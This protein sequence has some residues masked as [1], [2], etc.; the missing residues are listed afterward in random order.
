MKSVFS[1][2]TTRLR[3]GVLTA[4]I[5]VVLALPGQT[6]PTHANPYGGY[7]Q[8]APD[9]ADHWYC[10]ANVSY[11]HY[12]FWWAMDHLD[13]ATNI[14]DVY[15]SYCG[16][17][18]DVVFRYGQSPTVPGWLQPFTY[19]FT[20]CATWITYQSKCEQYYV[21]VDDN[22][23]W[24][25][26]GGDV[27]LWDFNMYHVITHEVGHTAGLQHMSGAEVMNA[28][29]FSFINWAYTDYSGHDACH[30]NNYLAGGSC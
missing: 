3:K 11:D 15:S 7:P 19:G 29:P 2:P 6:T 23:I 8:G 26:S 27:D 13:N 28:G 20:E 24:N 10:Y 17:L 18:T 16:S 12:R 25:F 1:V 9:S 14:Y 5:A 30:V 4:L 21:W 22:N